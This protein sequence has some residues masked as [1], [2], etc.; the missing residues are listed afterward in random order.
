MPTPDDLAGGI[1]DCDELL[2][3]DTVGSASPAKLTYDGTTIKAQDDAGEYNPRDGRVTIKDEGVEIGSEKASEMD[4]AGVGVTVTQVAGV[5]NEGKKLITIPGVSAQAA[6]FDIHLGW[7]KDV[8]QSYIKFASPNYQGLGFIFP[9]TDRVGTPADIRILA[10]VKGAGKF[11]DFRIYDVDNAQQIAEKISHGDAEFT[12]FSLG[13]I[14][15]LPAGEAWW[16]I[17]GRKSATT[18]DEGQIK[19][20]WVKF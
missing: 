20:I 16:E 3:N 1:T 4:F 19:A 5:G 11:A 15:N 17:Q 18:G 12:I 13:T 8:T 7:V 2:I 10:R 6:S 14:A 9:G